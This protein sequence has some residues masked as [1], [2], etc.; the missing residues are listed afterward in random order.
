MSTLAAG[1]E[2]ADLHFLGK[3]EV[4]ATC[5]L[6]DAAGVTLIDPGPSTCLQTLR[7][8]L[9]DRGFGPGDI[10]SI[11]LTHIHLDHGGATGTLVQENPRIRVRV[12]PRGAPHVIDPSR[13]LSSATRLYGA[14]MERLWGAVLPVPAGNVQPIDEGED[15]T[16]GGRALRVAF[17]P[18]HAS[19]HVSFFDPSSGI[20]FVG[21]VGGIRRGQSG[22]V[23][24]PTPPPDIDL[25][26]WRSSVARIEQW[27][28]S[29]IFLTHFGPFHDV[30]AHLQELLVR[31]EWVTQLA[32]GILRDGGSPEE[33]ASKFTAAFR[34]AL[35]SRMTADEA[36]RYEMA[37]P[38]EYNWPGLLRE[39]GTRELDPRR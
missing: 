23:M 29:T 6:H 34:R 20:A 26:L 7:T 2:Y 27:R 10:H 38:L 8:V 15:L 14:G 9:R 18:G 25:D 4:I 28:P 22:F 11:L 36:E 33:Q 17:T 3:P 13:L 37:G 21:D 24:P 39:L 5:L 31:L 35:R 32:L 12:H 1:I 19:H 16:A 30:A